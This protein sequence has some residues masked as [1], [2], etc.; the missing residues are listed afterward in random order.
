MVIPPVATQVAN[1]RWLGR[2]PRKAAIFNAPDGA[3]G[4]V[5]KCAWAT[6]LSARASSWLR[7]ACSILA[8]G[9]GEGNGKNDIIVTKEG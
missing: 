5:A 2:I 8:C 3:D 6:V 7:A 1:S 9:R 4:Q